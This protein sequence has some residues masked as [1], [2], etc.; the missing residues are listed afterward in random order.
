LDSFDKQWQ[1]WFPEDKSGQTPPSERRG[2]GTG[3][4]LWILAGVVVLLFILL[5]IT[6]GFYTEWLWFSNL[7]YGSVYA[8]ILKTKILVFFCAAIIFCVLFLGNLVLAARLV[9]KREA[10]FW[11]WALASWLQRRIKWGVILGTAFLS[12]I[13][14]MVAQGNWQTILEFFNGQPFGITDPVLHREVSFYVFSLPFFEL[15]RG[16]LVGALIITLLGSAGVYALSYMVQRV[17]FDY[18][19]PVLA[20][21]GGLAIAILGLFAWGY[22]LGIWELVFSERGAVFA[23][24]PSFPHNGFLS[25]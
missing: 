5:N 20:H 14:G 18:A 4:V 10:H 12:L 16:W 3:R 7:G 23:C 22:W 15:L 24:M 11:L 19:R 2:G 25:P 17:S 21:I 9:P 1:R 6:K 8:T 13:F